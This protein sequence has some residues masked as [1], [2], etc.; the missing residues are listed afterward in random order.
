MK[1]L[2]WLLLL[3]P[4]SASGQI[5]RP[6]AGAGVT[7]GDKGGVVVSSSGGVWTVDTDDDDFNVSLWGDNTGTITHTYQVSGTDPVWLYDDATVTLTA[8]LDVTGD[9]G[10]TSLSNVASLDATTTTTVA[11]AAAR[12]YGALAGGTTLTFGTDHHD[13]LTANRTWASF[14]TPANG[15]YTSLLFDVSGGPWT[16]DFH[17][18]NS[19]SVYR[20]LSGEAVAITAP[21]TFSNGPNWFSVTRADGKF[22]LK[23]S[24][25]SGVSD[26]WAF[27]IT[28]PTTAATTGTTKIQPFHAPFD[29][30]L[31]RAVLT[32]ATAPTGA[33]LI[34]D[35]HL[36][37]T[38]VMGTDKLDIEVSEFSTRTA[39]TAP[40]LTVTAVSEGD[41]ITFD[42][43][44]V[45]STVA[46][47][48]LIVYVYYTR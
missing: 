27:A 6:G 10:A 20:I 30:T 28:D 3:F 11:A 14:G 8:D 23:D 25:V 2:F 31:T 13:S 48:G 1:N 44:Q 19:G 37:G 46:G 35:I 7:D 17:T 29:C 47:A 24:G 12:P 16:L 26:V 45:G 32:A 4:F 21:V 38:T 39:A 41:Q 34:A 36:G 18:N 43:D 9:V 33:E 42:V 15:L 22:Y 40:A 5:E